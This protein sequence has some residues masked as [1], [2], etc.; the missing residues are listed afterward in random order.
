MLKKDAE[1]LSTTPDP[2]QQLPQM[3]SGKSLPSSRF[4]SKKLG[5]SKSHSH[6]WL[7]TY[8]YH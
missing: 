3:P 8:A 5:E 1:E 4:P 2:T 6:A 7:L